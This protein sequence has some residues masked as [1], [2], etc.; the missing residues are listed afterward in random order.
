MLESPKRRNV[1]DKPGTEGF[2]NGRP[3]NKNAESAQSGGLGWSFSVMGI[4]GIEHCQPQSG[5]D[6]D[7]AHAY[8]SSVSTDPTETENPDQGA[9][10]R[11]PKMKLPFIF[12]VS[13]SR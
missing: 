4:P 13:G 11:P 5:V 8:A 9:A 7:I 2:V 10:F 12:F 1:A 3:R 6:Q